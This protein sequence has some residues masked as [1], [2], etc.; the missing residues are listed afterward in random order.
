MPGYRTDYPNVRAAVSETYRDLPPD[1]LDDLVRE[2]FGESF[3]VEDAEGFFSTLAKIGQVAAPIILPAVGNALLPGVGGALG[4]VAGNF[5]SQALSRV[6]DDGAAAPRAQR[7]ATRRQ[8]PGAGRQRRMA[9]PRPTRPP[10]PAVSAAATAGE[11]AAAAAPAAATPATGLDSSAA[12]LAAVISRPEFLLALASSMFGDAGR[13]TVPVG[14]ADVPVGSLLNLAPVLGD[15]ARAELHL[16]QGGAVNGV[17]PHLLTESGEAKCDLTDDSERAAVLL[18]MLGEVAAAEAEELESDEADED[19]EDFS[20]WVDE[21]AMLD[22][23]ELA[24][25]ELDE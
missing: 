21:A 24:M 8:A 23:Y 19:F 9:L 20:E 5:A 1:R 17:P 22:A 13:P 4:S 3:A 25:L 10:A 6:G 18:G 14:D 11:P 15:A 2:R 12:Q 16:A 7:R